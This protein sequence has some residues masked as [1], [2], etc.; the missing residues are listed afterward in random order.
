MRGWI[1]ALLTVVAALPACAAGL[2]DLREAADSAASGMHEDAIVLY[3][4]ALESQELSPANRIEAYL[5]RA[6]EYGIGGQHDR[7]VADYDEAIRLGAGY[8]AYERRG[9]AQHNAGRP[10]KAVAD[11]DAAIRLAQAEP[12]PYVSRAGAHRAMG[13]LD[14]A[15]ADFNQAVRLR[16]DSEAMFI[17]R[18]KVYFLRAEY[19][20][21][22]DDFARAV[23]MA[24]GISPQV[25]WL[26]LA[27]QRAGQK[28]HAEFV[29]NASRVDFDDWPGQLIGLH[30]GRRTLEVVVD[31][32]K[33]G[34]AAEKRLQGCEAPLHLGFYALNRGATDEAK[35]RFN[36]A[37]G[38]CPATDVEAD[39]AKAELAR[40]TK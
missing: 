2:D 21:A 14:K 4:R 38:A 9:L 15:I 6:M 33:W 37:R 7:A 11:F 16:S 5:G 36:A 25:L 30:V 18:G 13:A 26:H 27:R 19:L 31:A 20:L 23:A 24:P 8:D 17:G 32:A 34:S 28:D 40:L 10:D 39:I 35:T 22:I 29:L 3:G 12:G 1:I